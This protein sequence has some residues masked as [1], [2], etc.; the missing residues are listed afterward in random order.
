M[1]IRSRVSV[2]LLPPNRLL[3]LKAPTFSAPSA[4]FLYEQTS[5]FLM[6]RLGTTYRTPDRP[7]LQPSLWK[8]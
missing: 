5:Q 8:P 3:F 2:S 4:D 1:V 6:I 7:T